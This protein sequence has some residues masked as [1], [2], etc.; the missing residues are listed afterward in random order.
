MTRSARNTPA[1]LSLFAA[2]PAIYGLL[3]LFLGWGL[4]IDLLVRF[5]RTESALV[6]ATALSFVVVSLALIAIL[7]G[8]H[9]LGRILC[10]GLITIVLSVTLAQSLGWEPV[11]NLFI[12]DFTGTERMAPITAIGFLLAVF[13][14]NRLMAEKLHLVEAVGIVG[15]SGFAF[16]AVEGMLGIMDQRLFSGLSIQTSLLFATLF[17][18]LCFA[19]SD[20]TPD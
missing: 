8:E 12:N 1:I 16:L 6:P 13:A 2:I 11:T 3:A 5:D 9:R 14:L 18:A 19:S 20:H 4:N 17:L 15:T 10:W 7:S